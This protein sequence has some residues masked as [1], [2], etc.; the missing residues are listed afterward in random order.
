MNKNNYYVN[1]FLPKLDIGN[2]YEKQ[3]QKQII[4]YFNNIYYVLNS[5]NNNEYD[6]ELSNDMKYEVKADIMAVKT[7]NIYMEFISFN[8]PSGI[9]TTK[10]EFYIIILPFE[11]SIYILIE[12]KKLK[13]LVLNKKYKFIIHPNYK[14]NYTSGYIFDKYVIINNGILI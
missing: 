5:C 2:Y 12:V 9:Y 10:A 14:N 7:N 3:A 11:I 1:E 6:F 4:K 13:E 8:K